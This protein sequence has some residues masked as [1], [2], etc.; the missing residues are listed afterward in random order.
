MKRMH[1]HVGVE[2]LDDGIRFYNALFGEEP[3]KITDDY[4]KWMLDDP[5]INFAISTRVNRG[6]DHLGFQVEEAEELDAVRVRLKQA[7]MTLF[8]EGETVCCYARSDK[9]WV[10]D[11]AGTAWEAYLHMEDVQRFSEATPSMEGGACC[12]GKGETRA[13]CCVP[14]EST[15]DKAA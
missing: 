7:D 5:R 9:S 12:L 2:K 3:S 11:P 13:D 8:D 15:T 10:T 6:V 4:A 1:I 14:P